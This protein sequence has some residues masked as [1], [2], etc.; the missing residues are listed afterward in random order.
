MEGLDAIVLGDQCDADGEQQTKRRIDQRVELGEPTSTNALE[1]T[2]VL[3]VTNG[4][5]QQAKRE[6]ERRPSEEARRNANMKK[7]AGRGDKAGEQN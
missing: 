4:T 5:C 7:P 6:R 1:E 2:D 3:E